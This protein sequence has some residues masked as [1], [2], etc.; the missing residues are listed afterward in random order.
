MP[1]SPFIHFGLQ[2]LSRKYKQ[3]ISALLLESNINLQQLRNLMR[4]G[5]IGSSLKTTDVLIPEAMH[6]NQTSG[7]FCQSVV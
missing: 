2:Q 3:S 7:L 1:L 5:Q 4:T 6:G